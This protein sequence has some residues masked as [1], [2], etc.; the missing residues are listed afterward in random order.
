[1]IADIIT[2]IYATTCCYNKGH[3]YDIWN[4]ATKYTSGCIKYHVIR[5]T[6]FEN[7]WNFNYKQKSIYLDVDD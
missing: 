3:S 5:W 4:L 1:M 6:V 7:G 2:G